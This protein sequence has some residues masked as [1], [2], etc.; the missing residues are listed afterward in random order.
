MTEQLVIFMWK[1]ARP[2]NREFRQNSSL[3]EPQEFAI[4]VE[5]PRTIDYILNILDIEAA[6]LVS[7]NVPIPAPIYTPKA[8]RYFLDKLGE[9]LRDPEDVTP[10]DLQSADDDWG[11]ND[12]VPKTNQPESD[13]WD[14]TVETDEK[15][16]EK[17]ES[18]E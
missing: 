13:P 8:V 10:K 2:D 9:Y 7:G 16:N 4:G 3:L 11:D 17:E 18:W 15:W 6:E 14:T 1:E 12:N 5:I